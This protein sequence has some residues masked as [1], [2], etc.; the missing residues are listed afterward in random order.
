[1]DKPSVPNLPKSALA[2]LHASRSGPT[3]FFSEVVAELKKVTWPTRAET[4]KLTMAVIVISLAVGLFVGG[5]DILFLNI[6]S[7]LF[8]H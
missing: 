8:K 5:L 7:L 4:I 6:T 1:M 2:S 3:K